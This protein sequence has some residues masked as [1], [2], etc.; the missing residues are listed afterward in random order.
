MLKAY[1]DVLD[2]HQ[3][4][5]VLCVSTKT[6]YRLLREGIIDSLKIGRC[7]RVPKTYLLN[8]LQS[9]GSVKPFV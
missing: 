4:A 7:Y 8:Y 9:A 5:E 1:P 6:C 2:I 3:I